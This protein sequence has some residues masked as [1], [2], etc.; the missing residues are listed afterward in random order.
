LAEIDIEN[1]LPSDD[2]DDE[3]SQDEEN[4]NEDILDGELVDP[5]ELN[6]SDDFSDQDPA[7]LSDLKKAKK[8]FKKYGPKQAIRFLEKRKLKHG[9]IGQ[10]E[11]SRMIGSY[12]FKNG[13]YDLGRISLEWGLNHYKKNFKLD[14]KPRMYSRLVGQLALNEF[15]LKR[16]PQAL[17]YLKDSTFEIPKHQPSFYN[18]LQGHC[19]YRLKEPEKAHKNYV[20]HITAQYNS[21]GFYK[22]NWKA[23]LF[24]IKRT[25]KD[26][27]RKKDLDNPKLYYKK[28]LNFIK[29]PPTNPEDFNFD[30]KGYKGI[31]PRVMMKFMKFGSDMNSPDFMKDILDSSKDTE[32]VEAVETL[33]K[34]E[35]NLLSQCISEV[36]K[37]PKVTEDEE[38]N[39]DY[40]ERIEKKLEINVEE[41]QN[42][43]DSFRKMAAK[44]TNLIESG[45]G[46]KAMNL[47][48]DLFKL[49]ELLDKS[50][51][52]EEYKICLTIGKLFAKK[53]R[54]NEQ[55]TYYERLNKYECNIHE[56][57]LKGK[58]KL[59]RAY[60]RL[61]RYPDAYRWYRT[62]IEN[63]L[64]VDENDANDLKS[65]NTVTLFYISS[66]KSKGT[67]FQWIR[68][69]FIERLRSRP[70]LYLVRYI[71][72]L[73]S[74]KNGKVMAKFI[75]QEE[76]IQKEAHKILN[77]IKFNKQAKFTKIA[78]VCH[79]LLALL[80]EE[81]PPNMNAFLE[82]LMEVEL[83]QATN[84]NNIV[85]FLINLLE[86]W[87]HMLPEKAREFSLNDLKQDIFNFVA[88]IRKYPRCFE[89]IKEL[90][91]KLKGI[92]E[93]EWKP[94]LE[95]LF[96]MSV[97][98]LF[99]DANGNELPASRRGSRVL[100]QA[101]FSISEKPNLS[102]DKPVHRKSKV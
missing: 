49:Y 3:E 39:K 94:K 92:A 93:D 31:G 48:D 98:T 62:Y 24:I 68:A 73:D 21:K 18:I 69:K 57:N 83:S 61:E 22:S 95:R 35:K 10:I 25:L 91:H 72:I 102:T 32:A 74:F 1:L 16:Y 89:A 90:A 54:F 71:D 43:R 101:K 34:K 5:S 52:S 9:P 86:I 46:E 47:L 7:L 36:K 42:P 66:L 78:L 85:A 99:L 41:V 6:P 82:G 28:M 60:F 23:N 77:N 64:F 26:Y 29:R 30:H 14:I 97:P 20:N 45:Q 96:R 40:Y 75:D 12:H 4:D 50:N 15:K 44:V 84:I 13:R 58:R 2:E 53:K 59:G 56:F 70:R 88:A 19:H 33:P 11:F 8:I 67:E 81:K 27:A 100:S 38:D 55:V 87:G 76:K 80:S 51:N 37:I 79:H 65:L 17:G 63:H